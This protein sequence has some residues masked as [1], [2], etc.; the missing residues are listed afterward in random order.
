MPMGL[1]RPRV[2]MSRL[3]VKVPKRKK[4]KPAGVWATAKL[5]ARST[6]AATIKIRR[7]FIDF[8]FLNISV[9]P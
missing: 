8:P 3:R 1:G 4:A 6:A 7:T 9:F 5:E 2:L